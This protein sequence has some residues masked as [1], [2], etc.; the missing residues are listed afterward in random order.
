LILSGWIQRGVAVR[1]PDETSELRRL[2]V[3]GAR[4]ARTAHEG[5]PPTPAAEAVVGEIDVV[6]R[7]A[8]PVAPE[9]FGVLQSLLAYLLAACGDDRDAVIP[10]SELIERFTIAPEALEEHLSLL[11]LVNFGGGC[12]AVYAEQQGDEVHV[13]KELFGDTFRGPP[14]LTPLEARAIR[15]ALE[16]VGPMVAAGAHS[17]LER[18]RAK[19][20]ETFGVFELSRTPTPQAGAEED[21]V[22]TLTRAIADHKIVELEYLKPESAEVTTRTVE[23][24]TIE[25]RLPHWYVHAWDVDRDAPRSY[26]LDRTRKV[27]ALRKG[28]TPRDGFDPAELQ[29]ST[30]AR[31]WYSPE[32]ARWEVEKGA[33]PLIDGAAVSER[34]VGSTEW[35]IGEVLSFRGEA[36][37]LA[38]VELRERVAAR[39]RELE[40]ELRSR[41]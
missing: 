34:A 36:V 16:F 27:K 21:L 8:G 35:L 32:V 31:I 20:E 5:P 3:E 37:I 11:N 38:P 40:R 24:Y 19:L 26:R 12:Y 39:A 7:F 9:R 17:P 2:V 4:A 10:A 41:A 28:F 22:A 23:P 15:L 30:T 1:D 18:V 13:E 29:Q 14:R 25:R 6:E 33:I